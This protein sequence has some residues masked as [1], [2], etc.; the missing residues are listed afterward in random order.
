MIV[1]DASQILDDGDCV[2]ISLHPTFALM[3]QDDNDFMEVEYGT[4]PLAVQDEVLKYFISK[5]FIVGQAQG[6]ALLDI[7]H[8]YGVQSYPVY[9]VDITD[10]KFDVS[11]GSNKLFVFLYG[12]LVLKQTRIS[13]SGEQAV[14]LQDLEQSAKEGFAKASNDGPLTEEYGNY[15]GD[16][17]G[18]YMIYLNHETTNVYMD[19]TYQILGCE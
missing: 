2:I 5:D 10:V 16:N 7:R 14:T 3:T 8:D 17:V 1:N 9:D 15:L 13:R 6:Y 12:T 4:L 18:R 11:Q 19:D